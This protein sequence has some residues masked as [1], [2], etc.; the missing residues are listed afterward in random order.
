MPDMANLAG[1]MI[2]VMRKTM[3]VADS[4]SA[5]HEHRQNQR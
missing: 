4:L 5:K 3:R 1:A 2:F